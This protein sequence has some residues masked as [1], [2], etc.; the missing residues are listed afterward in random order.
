[1]IFSIAAMD[2]IAGGK[3]GSSAYF[4]NFPTSVQNLVEIF[5]TDSWTS[6]MWGSTSDSC[7]ES[8]QCNSKFNNTLALVLLLV[9]FFLSQFVLLALFIA[10][11]LDNFGSDSLDVSDSDKTAFENFLQFA[12]MK[13]DAMRGK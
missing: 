7:I 3:N 5:V 13:V 1:M 10:V 9:F 6:I 8:T 2:L 4:D 12:R 11:I